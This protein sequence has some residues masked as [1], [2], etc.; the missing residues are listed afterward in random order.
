MVTVPTPPFLSQTPDIVRARILSQVSSDLDTS[1]GSTIW[2]LLAPPAQEFSILWGLLDELVALGFLQSAQGEYLYARGEER[3]VF[4]RPAHRAAGTVTF[5]GTAGSTISRG[6]VVSNTV[7]GGT[8]DD[9]I[10][11][12][13][14]QE[15]TIG[16]GKTT[17]D[18][19]ITAIDTGVSGNLEAGEVNQI[20]S[21]VTGVDSVT[22]AAATGGGSDAE[23]VEEFR[24]RALQFVRA[25][26]GSG[27][28]DDYR[29]WTQEVPGTGT[30]TIQPVWNGA[31][32]VRV[33][34]VDVDGD[35]APTQ[36]LKE[37]ED[38][39]TARNP[40]GS[41]VTIAA[42]TTV[43]VNVA[44]DISVG[45]GYTVTGLE[46]E[47]TAALRRY[48]ATLEVGE[49]V[50]LTKVGA[51]VAGVSGVTDYQTLTLA[52]AASNKV[53]SA[54]QLAILGTVSLT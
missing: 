24:H 13:T 47:V 49:D 46:D 38:Y 33:L 29:I 8:D 16:A 7:I 15:V 27:T 19:G 50:V 51:V 9:L 11:F 4:Q 39:V 1:E 52:G 31:G 23:S 36:L 34:V 17:V 28:P 40:I 37:V 25:T 12:A 5:T 43:T 22:N 53:I 20:Q 2:N 21:A 35:P 44:V 26:R 45:T 18:V 14:D 30:P 6:T 32:T 10:L 42:P 54:A 3:G 48:F 41:T